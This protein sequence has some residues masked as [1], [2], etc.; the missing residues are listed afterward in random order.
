MCNAWLDEAQS[1]IKIAG[2]N[3]N[4]LRLQMSPPWWQKG[5]GTKQLLDE[6][7]RREWKSALKQHSKNEV[8]GSSPITSRQIDGETMERVT[9]FICLGSK[10]TADGDC[11]HVIKRCLLL[12][13][14]AMTNLDCI[15]KSRD[16]FA[17]K[18]P[19]SQSYGFSNSHYGCWSR[20]IKIAGHWSVDAFE[21][22]F[23]RRL[24][25]VPWT[26]RRSNQSILKEINPE[27]SL[28]EL[29]LTLKLQYL[30]RRADSLEKT[31]LLGKIE[32]WRRR[33]W[34]RLRWLHGIT[35]SMNMSK[36]WEMVDREAWCAAVHGVAKSWTWLSDW[37]TIM[38][39][40]SDVDITMCFILNFSLYWS[41]VD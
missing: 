39:T 28:A 18:D 24:L 12:G 5:R 29:M 31:L 14:K 38:C 1:G 10:I 37:R 7:E 17:N 9:D 11:S 36:L 22:W 2:R 27:Y 16:Y 23:W 25:R 30:M 26:V 34:H 6:S 21:L 20:T 35:N 13:R 32:G 19:C 40:V 3:F 33:G 15:L 41:R 8:H 4:N